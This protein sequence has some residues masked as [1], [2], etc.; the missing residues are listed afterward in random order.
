M[1]RILQSEELDYSDVLILP[2]RSTITSRSEIF[3]E[4]EIEF[5][6]SGRTW[7][8]VPLACA[9]MDNLSSF[10]MANTLSKYHILTCLTK[11]YSLE[12]L[13]KYFNMCTTSSDYAHLDYVSYSLGISDADLNK[14]NAFKKEAPVHFVTIDTPNGYMERFVDFCKNFRLDNPS[15]TIIAGNV[16]TGEMVEEL[17]LNGV[18]IVK[19]GIG[20]G[21]QCTTRMK[22]AIGRPMVSMILECADKA[23]HHGIQLMADGGITSP[24]DACISFA[25]GAD[26]T[27]VGSQWSATLETGADIIEENG[28]QFMM[29]YGMSSSEAQKN[30]EKDGLKSYRA[31]EGRVSKIPYKGSIHPIIQDYLG[32][33]RSC[34]S[35][36]GSHTLKSLPKKATLVKVNNR[37]NTSLAQYTTNLL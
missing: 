5:K 4:R 33:L 17:A 1:T 11:H 26:F 34:C 13:I 15:V 19:A 21:A 35:Y 36:T 25:V 14:F 27:M 18:D 30:H 29:F 6:H 31:S 16:C 7:Q 20:G 10:Q 23:H 3:L 8:G 12:E 32:G 24:G 9:N 37:L 2:A 22:S 28:K